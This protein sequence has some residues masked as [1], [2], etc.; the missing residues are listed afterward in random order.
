M[1]KTKFYKII[2]WLLFAGAAACLYISLRT[3]YYQLEY[4]FLALA[5]WGGA[6]GINRLYKKEEE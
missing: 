6:F 5:F 4:T 2:Y 1:D 3:Q